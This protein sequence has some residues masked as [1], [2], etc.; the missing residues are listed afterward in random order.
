MRD[1]PKEF[2]QAF[3]PLHLVAY[4]V[5]YSVVGD[6][7]DAQD[8][9]QEALARALVRWSSVNTFA[10]AWV[11]RVAGNLAL[12]RLR[13]R[14]RR[15]LRR[16]ER[17]AGPIAYDEERLDLVRALRRLPR[18]QRQV[19]VMRFL[20]DLTEADVAAALGCSIGTVKQHTSRGLAALRHSMAT[21]GSDVPEPA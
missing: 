8:I 15:D 18:R 4:R 21:G 12:D 19:V 5:A 2:E 16:A 13:A 9:A 1:G 6:R 17:S 10:E 14:R 20:G 7:A 3:V 11:V